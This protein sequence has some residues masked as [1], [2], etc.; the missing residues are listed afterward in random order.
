MTLKTLLSPGPVHPSWA[1]E[2]E[3]LCNRQGS[4]SWLPVSEWLREA[5][6]SSLKIEKCLL[7]HFCEGSSE[8]TGKDPG[9]GAAWPLEL[10]H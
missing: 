9:S 6:P 2:G 1:T 3:S 5:M 8:K 7:E 10:Q 4:A